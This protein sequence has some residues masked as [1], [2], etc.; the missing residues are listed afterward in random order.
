[1]PRTTYIE[2][3]AELMMRNT[4]DVETIRRWSQYTRSVH[5]QFCM[6]PK[7]NTGAEEEHDIHKILGIHKFTSFSSDYC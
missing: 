4:I 7:Q 6:P 2:C 1:M 3:N 5:H